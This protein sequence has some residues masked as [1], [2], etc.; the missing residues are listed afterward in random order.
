MPGTAQGRVLDEALPRDQE[1]V[2]GSRADLGRP[3]ISGNVGGQGV[4]ITVTPTLTSAGQA[5]AY[6]ANDYVGTDHVAMTFADAVRVNGG[7]GIIE[8]VILEDDALQSASTELWLFDT[9]PAGLPDDNAAFTIT[10]ASAKTL[11]AVIPFV[12]YYA[13]ALNSASDAKAIGKAFN[14]AAGVHDIYGVLVTRGTP[15]YLSGCLTIRLQI[16]QD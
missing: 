7:S 13:S 4:T 3:L 9:L 12:T 15:T 5:V 10:D 11:I 16:M 14:A 1:M 8:S 2:A 6:H